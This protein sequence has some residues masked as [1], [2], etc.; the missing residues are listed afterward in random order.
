VGRLCGVRNLYGLCWNFEC[1][2]V[3][4]GVEE[5]QMMFVI[6][7]IVVWLLCCWKFV[8][9]MI[10]CWMILAACSKLG[11]SQNMCL[12]YILISAWFYNAIFLDN[13][14]MLVPVELGF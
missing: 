3:G 8:I 1:F 7:V 11:F 6:V 9:V 10:L 5:F 13:C 14:G 4:L 12:L 2:F